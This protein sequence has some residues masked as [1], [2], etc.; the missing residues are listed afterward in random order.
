MKHQL[1]PL[2]HHQQ[3]QVVAL[4]MLLSLQHYPDHQ[5]CDHFTL[6]DLYPA[7]LPPEWATRWRQ[8]LKPPSLYVCPLQDNKTVYGRLKALDKTV[9]VTMRSLNPICTLDESIHVIMVTVTDQ[10][11]HRI[12]PRPCFVQTQSLCLPIPPKAAVAR[13]QVQHCGR[14]ALMRVKKSARNPNNGWLLMTE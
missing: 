1:H 7:H 13:G 6:C 9:H 14:N 12:R 8:A 5:P 2:L 10:V 3:S 4:L 11:A